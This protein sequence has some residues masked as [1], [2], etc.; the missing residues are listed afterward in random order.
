MTGG[1]YCLD[2]RHIECQDRIKKCENGI[3]AGRRN[4]SSWC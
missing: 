2:R 1:L 3:Y 4:V